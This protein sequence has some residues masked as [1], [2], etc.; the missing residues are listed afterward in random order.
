M[1]AGPPRDLNDPVGELGST[2]QRYHCW[3]LKDVKLDR[4]NR[5]R[6]RR[7]MQGNHTGQRGP[8]APLPTLQDCLSLGHG[9]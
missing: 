8:A 9:P 4:Q 3:R 2:S 5:R 7:A 6:E 1:E